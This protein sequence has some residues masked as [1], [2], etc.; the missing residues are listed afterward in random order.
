MGGVVAKHILLLD[1]YIP[2]SIHT[3]FTLSTPHSNPPVSIN[4]LLSDIYSSINT[5]LRAYLEDSNHNIVIISIASGNNDILIPLDS[6]DIS[7]L[8]PSDFGISLYSTG[9]PQVWSSANHK[10][11]V[12]CKQLVVSLSNALFIAHDNLNDAKL[13]RDSLLNSLDSIQL[14]SPTSSRTTKPSA[15]T[16]KVESSIHE[17][18]PSLLFNRESNTSILEAYS[19]EIIPPESFK[20]CVFDNLEYECNS[21]VFIQQTQIPWSFSPGSPTHYFYTVN[22]YDNYTLESFYSIESKAST[23]RLFSSRVIKRPSI[24]TKSLSLFGLSR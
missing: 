22:S 9:I 10:C 3:L 18:K 8:V 24:I 12:W 7:I 20:I 1:D 15:I 17:F 13:R 11:V 19:S 4:W 5:R 14:F 2:N 16:F 21:N 6:T 23:S